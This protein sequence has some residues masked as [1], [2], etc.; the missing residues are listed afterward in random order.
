VRV[1]TCCLKLR[2]NRHVA[3]RRIAPDGLVETAVRGA[4]D[5]PRPC[6][7]PKDGEIGFAV[8]VIVTGN[9]KVTEAAP[10][11]RRKGAIGGA[12]NEPLASGL[13]IYGDISLS[14]AVIVS[15]HGNVT[16][17]APLNRRK[18]AI[19]EAANEPLASG[20]A[21]YGEISG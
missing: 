5:V 20:P 13:A 8:G 14:V 4:Q 15:G 10:L 11:E 16:R 9:G 18:A 17:A 12:E 6:G 1:R 19:G 7:R 2:W 3:Q 21:I